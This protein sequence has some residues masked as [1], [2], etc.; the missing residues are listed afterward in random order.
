MPPK[1][2]TVRELLDSFKYVRQPSDTYVDIGVAWR[3]HL[4]KNGVD[5]PVKEV[6]QFQHFD[7]Y[8]FPP[9]QEEIK[10]FVAAPATT[11]LPRDKHNVRLFVNGE[12]RAFYVVEMK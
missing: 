2:I 4:L 8:K 6:S 11:V 12:L 1:S 9:G 10:E 5:A 3:N 7:F